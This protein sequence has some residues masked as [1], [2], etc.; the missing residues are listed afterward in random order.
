MA[1]NS[2]PV[3]PPQFSCVAICFAVYIFHTCLIFS[4]YCELKIYQCKAF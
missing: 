2:S 3:I 1:C 4:S